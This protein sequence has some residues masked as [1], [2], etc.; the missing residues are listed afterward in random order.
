MR[1]TLNGASIYSEESVPAEV[2]A[3]AC[4][5]LLTAAPARITF[6]GR[7]GSGKSTVAELIRGEAWPCHNHADTIKSEVVEWLA[8]ALQRGFDPD[9]DEAFL[10][11]SHFM[12]L[13]PSR[14]RDDLWDLLGPVYAT[15]VRLYATA[16]REKLAV[17]PHLA[18]AEQVALVERHKPLFREPLQL[19]GQ[20]SKELAADPYHWVKQTI[21]RS[22]DHP[23][24][25]NADT[26]FSEEMEAL[27]SCGWVG[28][29]LAIDDATQRARRPEMTERERQHVSEWGITPEECDLVVDA[30]RPLGAV[31]LQIAGYLVA[32]EI[33]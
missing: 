12:G 5:R 3:A 33:A 16:R 4:R 25:F 10:H 27:R 8:G 24:C 28:V 11:F 18:L 31:L 2:A 17:D 30:N 23:V 26:R 32:K 7:A 1:T 9:A 19:Y 22:L 21:G 13:S 15:F 29:Y 6:A 14:V 20:M